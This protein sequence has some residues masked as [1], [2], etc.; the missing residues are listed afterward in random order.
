MCVA[1]AANCKLKTTINH[2]PP[3]TS[4]TTVDAVRPDMLVPSYDI[5]LP[6]GTMSWAY[7]YEIEWSDECQSSL[8]IPT[9]GA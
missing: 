8:S 4:V 7:D 6:D 1:M 2:F 5:I 3:G 9:S